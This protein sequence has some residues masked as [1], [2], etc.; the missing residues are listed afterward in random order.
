MK[1]GV[2]WLLIILMFGITGCSTREEQVLD[3]REIS[4]R[5]VDYRGFSQQEIDKRFTFEQAL[6][7]LSQIEDS[8]ESFR[9]L[10][11]RLMAG[12]QGDLSKVGN[13]SWEV[14]YLGFPNWISTVSGT[15]HKYEYLLAQKDYQLAIERFANGD[16]STDELQ[17]K[18]EVFST[19]FQDYQ[20]FIDEFV[21]VD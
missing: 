19:A 13:T 18:Q 9:D 21:I 17:A 20:M 4:R 15:L 12:N 3:H 2:T 16:I 5:E 6:V 8:L 7:R 10:T 14:Q 1:R 11:E